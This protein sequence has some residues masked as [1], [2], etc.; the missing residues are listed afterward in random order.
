MEEAEAKFLLKAFVFIS[1]AYLFMYTGQV[2]VGLLLKN[3]P[4]V[5]Y[6]IYRFLH[7][8]IGFVTCN[9]VETKQKRLKNI[10]SVFIYTLTHFSK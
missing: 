6:F 2:N 3:Y 4:D 10:S 9:R 8:Y 1:I 5:S 7:V